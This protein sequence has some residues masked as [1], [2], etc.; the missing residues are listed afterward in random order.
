MRAFILGNS[1]ELLDHDLDRLKGEAVFGVNALPLYKP[2]II[3]H[4]VCADIGMAFVPEVRELV[5]ES[6]IKYYSS[7]VWNTI[8]HEDNVN[9]YDTF[10]DRLIG[11][12]LS[13][14]KLYLCR[15][16]TYAA[17]QIAAYLGYNPI[18]TLGIDL[19]I[20]PNGKEWIPNQ[21]KL[22]ELLKLKNLRV[23]TD[24]KRSSPDRIH[25]DFMTKYCN[26]CFMFA[27]HELDKLG[28]EVYNL[29]KGGN[30]KAFPRRN[31]EEVLNGNHDTEI[32]SDVELITKE[33]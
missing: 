13:D 17:L 8:D 4:Y 26:Q 2:E 7:L 1:G 6:C 23:P 33:N 25:H 12:N 5:S 16:V 10:D 21:E 22:T 19:G 24:D 9:V 31:F 18:Y 30:L 28:I 32:V 29:S 14:T 20:P 11:F 27:R 3:S 15:T